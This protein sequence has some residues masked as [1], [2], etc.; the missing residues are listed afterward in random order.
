MTR[1]GY[2][3]SLAAMTASEMHQIL[4]WSDKTPIEKVPIVS[5]I[6]RSKG[7]GNHMTKYG[8]K[9][10][11]T[12]YNFFNQKGVLDRYLSF[13]KF[14]VHRSKLIGHNR[15]RPNVDKIHPNVPAMKLASAMKMHWESVRHF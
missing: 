11:C 3:H 8:Q 9:F 6:L 5:K 7:Q 12:G 1:Y 13:L 4:N 15:A 2:K 10:K 14:G